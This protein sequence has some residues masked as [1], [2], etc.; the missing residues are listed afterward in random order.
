MIGGIATAAC[1]LL[2]PDPA[3]AWG[4]VAHIDFA[5]QL[6]GG[7]SALSPAVLALIRARRLDFLYG[8][9]AADGIVGKNRARERDHCHGWD[10]AGRL[11]VLAREAGDARHAM[12]LGYLS[13]LGADVVAH[14]HIVPQMLVTHYRSKGVG[15]LYWEARADHRL[16][17]LSPGL[18]GVWKELAAGD[19]R[20]HDLFLARQLV[21]TLFSNAVSARIWKEAMRIQRHGSWRGVVGRIDHRSRL[22]FEQ[23]DLV[24]WRALSVEAGRKAIERPDGARLRELDPVGREALALAAAKRKLLRSLARLSRK[25]GDSLTHRLEHEKAL[26]HTLEVDI[27]MFEED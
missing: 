3:L 27:A 20:E 25:N 15:H 16:L 1:I 24:R 5:S 6:L 2:L 14:N 12:M 8:A 23:G 18:V 19:F 26:R 10:V 7:A 4:P 11:L 9:L 17:A 22:L 13:H 21:P